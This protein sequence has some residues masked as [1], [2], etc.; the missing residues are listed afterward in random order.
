MKSDAIGGSF[1][2]SSARLHELWRPEVRVQKARLC[3]PAVHLEGPEV[4]RDNSAVEIEWNKANSA[5]P[6]IDPGKEDLPTP[7]PPLASRS[8]VGPCL[9]TPKDDT[10][11]EKP[12]R[13]LFVGLFRLND[14]RLFDLSEDRTERNFREQG[15]RPVC[16]SFGPQWEKAFFVCQLSRVSDGRVNVFG[17]K[18]RVATKDFLSASPFRQAVEDVRDEDSRSFGAELPMADLRIT[19]QVLSPVN[20][21]PFSLPR[22]FLGLARPVSHPQ[23]L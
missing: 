10:L 11:V 7:D 15:F 8:N 6:S 22:R 2:G 1:T 16:S 23:F 3:C 5:I 13:D 20:H 12:D 18:R 19:G 9:L 4:V 17:P 21:G 14:N